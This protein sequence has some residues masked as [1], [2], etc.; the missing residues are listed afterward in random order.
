MSDCGQLKER[1][2]VSG[3]VCMVVGSGIIYGTIKG[4]N[5]EHT[6]KGSHTRLAYEGYGR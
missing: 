4:G 6:K 3:V 2:A 1:T 5:R